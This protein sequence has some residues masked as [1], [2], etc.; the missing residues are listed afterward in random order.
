M[1]LNRPLLGEHTNS[2][3]QRAQ[4]LLVVDAAEGGPVDVWLLA[5]RS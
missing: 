1:E 4:N 5:L 2:G 3:Y